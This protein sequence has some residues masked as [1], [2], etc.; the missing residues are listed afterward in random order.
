MFYGHTMFIGNGQ[1]KARYF[2]F[3]ALSLSRRLNSEKLTRF[4][5][6]ADTLTLGDKNWDE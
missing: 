5:I 1:K 4:K 2:I 3:P 6:A